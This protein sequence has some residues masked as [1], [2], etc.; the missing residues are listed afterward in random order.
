MCVPWQSVQLVG[1]DT[2]EK[3]TRFTMLSFDLQDS[4]FGSLCP[5]VCATRTIAT[6]SNI[7]YGG[8]DF[9]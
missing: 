7:L 9:E 3:D 4:A 2:T 8:F 6:V 5:T 1:V